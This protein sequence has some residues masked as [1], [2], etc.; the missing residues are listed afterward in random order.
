MTKTAN[1]SHNIGPVRN[2]YM[3]VSFLPVVDAA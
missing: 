1:D 3:M 2:A